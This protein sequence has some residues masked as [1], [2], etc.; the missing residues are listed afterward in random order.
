M[1][2]NK[3]IIALICCRG[4]SKDI[5]NKNIKKFSGKP[6]LAWVIEEV[7]KTGIFDK[8]IISTDSKSIAKIGKFY[9]AYIPGL[10]PKILATD[11][12]DV[13]D[14]HKYIFSKLNY[15][16][17]NSYICVLN[18]NPFINS[19]FIK[20][21]F[22][23]S[24]KNKYNCVVLDSQKI[25]SDSLYYRQMKKKKNRLIPIFP[26]EFSKSKINRQFDNNFFSTINNIRWGRPSV[27]SNYNT[28]K[29][30]I[31]RNGIFPIFLPKIKN[32]DL[33]DLEDW[34]IAETIFNNFIK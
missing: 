26:K 22:Q 29:K 19:S 23:I 17:E 24:K 31:I 5:P 28:Y 21:S 7:K 32:F 15:T 13:F 34:K 18:N 1:A 14:T 8:I 10:R 9:G 30:F 4:G 11:N 2:R 16:D 27:L 20:T 3:K 25:K 12:S 33:D 6:L